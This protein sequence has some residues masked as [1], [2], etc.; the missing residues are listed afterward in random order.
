M[1]KR[2]WK[3]EEAESGKGHEVNELTSKLLVR[4]WQK[5]KVKADDA[6]KKSKTYQGFQSFHF[7]NKKEKDYF[8]IFK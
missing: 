7:V 6:I 8:D 4:A 1:M 2:G 5:S 3:K